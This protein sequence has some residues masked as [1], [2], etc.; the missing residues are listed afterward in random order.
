MRKNI[1]NDTRGLSLGSRFR[2]VGDALY[3]EAV[4]IIAEFEVDFKPKWFVVFYTIQL[5]ETV[6]VTE[7]AHYVGISHPAVSQIIK[8]LK[9]VGLVSS[10]TDK[11][12]ERKKAV[13]LSDK[14][15]EVAHRLNPMWDAVETVTNQMIMA[16]G[17]DIIDVMDK[18]EK[19]LEQ[20]SLYDRV[21]EYRKQQLL[22]EAQIIAYTPAH[23]KYFAQLNYEWLNKYF[24]VE[25]C[26]AALLDDPQKNII[27]K[28][29]YIC[30]AQLNGE[31]V[32]TCGLYKI[33]DGVYELIK[34]AVTD[35]AQGKQVGK[36][37]GL[38]MLEVAKQ[39]QASRV[40]LQSNTRLKPAIHLYRTL[41]FREVPIDES[42]QNY[43][44]ANIMMVYDI[45]DKKV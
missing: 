5:K 10:I 6:S 41:G 15:Q 30:F 2:K 44:R 37:L 29:G 7:I 23:Q 38:H 4:S 9:K 22:G 36:K 12:D 27:D 20:T 13:T 1:F 3:Q 39:Q 17:Y 43:E 28:G 31:I 42:S 21:M 35:K 34:M 18:F 24:K 14:G 26:D 25:P 19:Q 45:I 40:E 11:A 8:E 33:N 16:T 32:G